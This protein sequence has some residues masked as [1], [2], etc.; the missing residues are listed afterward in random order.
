MIAF[1]WGRAPVFTREIAIAREVLPG[2]R[3]TADQLVVLALTAGLM[4][5]LHLLFAHTTLGR[6]MRAASE[7]PALLGATGID[8]A[9]VVRWTCVIGGALAAVAGVFVGLTV[10][11]RPLLGFDLLCRSSPRSSWG[12]SAASTARW[13]GASSSASPRR[14]PFRSSGPNI[15]RPSRSWSCSWCS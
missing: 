13:P 5:A 14:C 10:Q 15:A 9:V 3:V 4:I 12:E 6:A 1:L 8:P 11:V 7:N 2:V